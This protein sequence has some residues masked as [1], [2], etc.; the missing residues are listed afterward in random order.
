VVRRSSITSCIDDSDNIIQ[1]PKLVYSADNNQ[2][3]L[4]YITV[5]RGSIRI[6]VVDNWEEVT[7][8]F[9]E[10]KWKEFMRIS[11]GNSSYWDYSR[12]LLKHWENRIVVKY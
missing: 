1:V 6:V 5:R 10:R 11:K 4:Q 9:L 8:K 3:T 2:S 12:I 7:E